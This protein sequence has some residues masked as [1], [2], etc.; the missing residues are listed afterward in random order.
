MPKYV[1]FLRN[2]ESWFGI[3]WHLSLPLH[4]ILPVLSL[5]LRILWKPEVLKSSLLIPPKV[6]SSMP[7]CPLWDPGG[8]SAYTYWCIFGAFCTSQWNY[9]RNTNLAHHVCALYCLHGVCMH[10]PQTTLWFKFQKKPFKTSLC[11]SL[12]GCRLYTVYC[13][14][15]KQMGYSVN[16]PT[17]QKY[18][19]LV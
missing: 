5:T 12:Y 1:V 10:M 8:N 2:N 14:P 17:L 9:T 4:K 6:K 7:S 13:T 3:F 15:R 19:A 16:V 18:L 11:N